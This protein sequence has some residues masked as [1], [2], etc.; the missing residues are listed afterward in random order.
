MSII[1][2][3]SLVKAIDLK[4]YEYK[5]IYISHDNEFYLSNEIYNL[6][7]YKNID[8]LRK[9]KKINIRKYI[10]KNIDVVIPAVHGRGYEDGVISAICEV[11]NVPYATPN[12]I[13][14][15]CIQNKTYTKN[16]L[17]SYGIKV[18][19]GIKINHNQ[20]Y[21]N[22]DEVIKVIEQLNYPVIIKPN[23]LGSSVGISIANSKNELL[24]SLSKAFKYDEEVLI[25]KSLFNFR[26]FNC[27]ALGYSEYIIGAIE[28]VI[29]NK[30]FYSYE[31]KYINDTKKILNPKIIEEL[32]KEIQ[33]TTC[34]ICEIFDISGVI[35]VDYLFD[36]KSN[37]LYVNEI[38]GIP[39]SFSYYLFEEKGIMYYELIDKLVNLAIK[40]YQKSK[41]KTK[42]FQSNILNVKYRS[43]K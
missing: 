21:T 17:N 31:N 18:L 12:Y 10:K 27:A 36:E 11:L 1:T 3:T 23:T 30:K 9:L 39:G 24:I 5:L 33:D 38:N 43:N 37:Q 28:E 35:R 25:E 6:E 42:I 7:K 14:L 13:S 32:E 15:A 26:E 20:Y 16:I 40:K 22:R 41:T 8:F 2:A 19:D 4:K 34:K 29:L